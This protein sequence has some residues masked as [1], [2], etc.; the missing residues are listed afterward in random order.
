MDYNGFMVSKSAP[1]KTLKTV[2]KTLLIDSADRDTTKYYTNGDFVVYLP[3]VYENVVSMRLVAA[4]FP[5]VYK[6]TYG[7]VTHVYSDSSNTTTGFKA[8]NDAAVAINTAYYFLVD[9][10]GMNK[11]DECA[12]G[13]SKSSFPDGFFAKI[14]ALANSYGGQTFIEYNDH[15]AEDNIARYSP[16]IGKIDRLHIRTRLHNQKDTN[17]GFLYW[18]TDGAIASGTN[19]KGAEFNLTLELEMLDNVFDDFSSLETHLRDRS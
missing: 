16:A 11:S 12:V 7:A 18:T 9:I 5:P 10:E 1:K 19:Q 17:I 8:T 13:S 6:V 4:E 14:P 3:R 15:S 2:K